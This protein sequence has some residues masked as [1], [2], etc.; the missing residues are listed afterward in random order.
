MPPRLEVIGH[1]DRLEAEFLRKQGVLEQLGG[2]ELL[3]RRLI[4][5]ATL[6]RVD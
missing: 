1:G 4:A 2:T 3:G 5:E 6:I